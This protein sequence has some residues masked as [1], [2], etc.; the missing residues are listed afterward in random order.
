MNASVHQKKKR[1]DHAE[2]PRVGGP[3][4][5]IRESSREGSITGK[6]RIAQLSTDR[7]ER[8]HYV[9]QPR[10]KGGEGQGISEGKRPENTVNAKVQRG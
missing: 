5:R 2:D 1:P 7:E 4:S 10:G 9:N 6:G 3:I 8:L